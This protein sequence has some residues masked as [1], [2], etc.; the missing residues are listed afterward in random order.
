M[1]LIATPLGPGGGFNWIYLVE[2]LVCAVLSIFFLFYFNRLV[3]TIV[4]YAIRAWTWRK[5]NAYIDI[6]AL[7]ISLLGGRIFFKSIRYHAHNITVFVHDGHITWRYWLAQVQDA[8]IFQ[9]EEDRPKR[10]ERSSSEAEEKASQRSSSHTQNKRSRSRSIGKAETAGGKKKDLPCRLSIKVSGVEAFIYNR[11][12]LYD[13]V[14]EATTEKTKPTSRQSSSQADSVKGDAVP[15]SPSDEDGKK[16]RFAVPIQRATTNATGNAPQ[17]PAIPVWLGLLPVKVECRRAAAAVGNENTPSVVTAKVEKA[18]GTIDAGKAATPLDLFKLLFNFEIENA[19]ARM[20]PNRDFK[21]LQLDAAQRILR[22]K[23]GEQPKDV[24]FEE[25]VASKVDRRW[26][27]F[28][29]LF[30]RSRRRS[31]AGSVRTASMDSFDGDVANVTEPLTGAPQWHGLARYLDDSQGPEHDEWKGI[32]YAKATT[33]VD[34]PKVGFRFYWDIPGKIPDIATD[35]ETLLNAGFADDINGSKP[36]DYGLDFFVHGGSVTYGPWAD[37]QRIHLQQVFFPAQYVDHDP[38]P[39]L[40]PGDTRINT[41]FKIYVSVEEA[42]TLRVPTREPSKDDQWRGHAD[43]GQAAPESTGQDDRDGKHGKHKKHHRRRKTKSNNPGVDARP[44]GWLDITVKADSTVNYSQDMFSR[45]DGFKNYLDLDVKATEMTSS[46]NHGL[47]WRSGPITLGADLS[48]PLTWN[49]LRRWPF[50][51]TIN[52]ME[53]FI[54]RDHMFLIIDI[55]NDWSS[56]AAPAFFTFVPYHYDINMTFKNWCMFLNVND[57]NIIDDPDN[58][59]RNDFVT[60]EGRHMDGAIH[61]PL[62]HYR[63]KRN[64]IVFEVLSLDMGMRMLSP[65]RNTMHQFLENRQVANLPKLTLKG[66]FDQNGEERPGLV[67]ILRFDIN[68]W[69]LDLKAYGQLIR[70]FINLKENYFGDYVHFKTLEEFQNASSDLEQA[71]LITAS[72]PNPSPINEMDVLLNIVVRDTTVMLPTNLYNGKEFVRIECPAADLNLR[73]VSYYLDMALNLSPLS[74]LNASTPSADESSEDTA[75]STQIYVSHVDLYGHRCFGLPPNEPAYVDQWDIDVGALTG[76]CSS[77][78]IRDLAFA[79]KAL[80]YGFADSENALPVFSPISF[81][82]VTFVQVKTDILR[83]W[84]HVGNDAILLAAQPITVSTNDWAGDRFS[85]RVSVMAPEVTLACIDARSV[86]RRLVQERRGQPVKTLALLQTGAT[87]DVLIRSRHFEEE[88]HKQ[89]VHLRQCDLRTHRVPFLIHR[90][91]DLPVGPPPD[92]KFEPPAM[93]YPVLPPPI[94]QAGQP[95]RRPSSIKSVRSVQETHL[96]RPKSSTSSIATSIRSSTAPGGIPTSKPARRPAASRSTSREDSVESSTSTVSNDERRVRLDLPP[97]TIAFSSSYAKPHFPLDL[98]EPDE[99][100]VP[101]Y[102]IYQLRDDKSETSSVSIDLAEPDIDQETSHTSVIIK[103]QPGIRAYVEPGMAFTVARLLG[104][105]A[106]RTPEDIMDS[107]TMDIMGT[108]DN[109]YK[110]K[111]GHPSVLEIAASLPGA[112]LRVVDQE[113]QES[114]QMD[115]KLTRLEQLVR[116][117]A[118]PAVDRFVQT[119]TLHTSSDGVEMTMFRK[120][121]RQDKPVLSLRVDDIL[122]WLSLG[123]SRCIHVTVRDT[124]LDIDG[125]KSVYLSRVA[126]RILNLVHAILP[127]FNAVQERQ[128]GMLHSLIYTLAQ[129]SDDIGNPPALSRMT[130][131]LRAFPEHYRNQDSWKILSRFRWI[132]QALPPKARDELLQRF[133]DN[134]L[135]CPSDSPAQVLQSWAGR[136]N[137]D[138]PNADQALVFKQLFDEMDSRAMDYVHSPPLSMTAQSE[139]ITL[140]INT[141]SRTSKLVLDETSVGLDIQPPTVPTGLMLVDENKR[142]KSTFQLHNDSIALALDWELYEIAEQLLPVMDEFQKLSNNAERNVRRRSATGK[143]EDE[144]DRHDFHIVVSTD[145]GSITLQTIN[146]RLLTRAEGLKMSLIGTTQAGGNYGPCATA[147]LNVDRAMMQLHGPERRIWQSLLTGPSLYVDH[148]QPVEGA[149][150]APSVVIAGAYN[151]LEIAIEEQVP[152]IVHVA[153]RIVLDEVAQVLRLVNYINDTR[154]IGAGTA[155]GG[156]DREATSSQIPP[157]LSIALLAGN[158]QLE[159]SLLQ[160]LSYRLDGTAAS[161]KLTPDLRGR[162]AFGLDFDIGRQNHAFINLSHNERYH[163]QLLELPPINGRVGYNTIDDGPYVNVATTVETVEIDAAAIQAVTGVVNKPEVQGIFR[164]VKGSIRDMTDHVNSLDFGVS[165]VERTSEKEQSKALYE[166]RFALL[167]IRVSGSTPRVRGRSTAEIEFGIGPLHMKASNRANFATAN[168]MIPEVKASVQDIGARLWIDDHGNHVPCGK[169]VMDVNVNFSIPVDDQGHATRELQLRSKSLEVNAYPETA[170]TM[171]DVIN[172]LQDRLRDLDVSKEVEYMRRLRDSRRQTLVQGLAGKKAVAG[173]EE[174]NFSLEDLLAIRTTISLQDIQISWL[175]NQQYAVLPKTRP[176]DTVLTLTSIEFTTR[177][178]NEA[179]LTITDVLLQLSRKAL[180]K[181]RRAA[182]SALLPQ[183]VFSV[184]YWKDGKD[185][186]V[187]LRA[188]GKPLDFKLESSFIIPIAAV[189]HSVE[190]CLDNFKAGTAAWQ[191]TPTATGAPRSKAIDMQRLASVIIEVDF[192]GAQVYM[193]GAGPENSSSSNQQGSHHGRYGQFAADGEL[194]ST[195]LTTPGI[196]LKAEYNSKG[197]QPRMNGELRI[198]ASSNKLLP[199]FVPLMVEVSKSV[200]QVVQHQPKKAPS[201]AS[202]RLS[203]ATAAPQRLLED[204]SLVS[205]TPAAIFGK[206]KVDLGLRVCKQEFAL[207]CQPIAKVD[208]KAALEDFY[209]TMNTVESEDAGHFFAMSASITGLAAQVKHVYSREPTFSFDMQSIVMSAMNS[210]HLSGDN[211][212]SAIIKFNPTKLSINAKQFQDLLIFR[213]I[214]LPPEIRMAQAA[215][216]VDDEHKPDDYFA[217]RYRN[218]AGS[219]AFP[220]NAT[221][222]FTELAVNMDLGQSIGKTAFTITDLWASQQKT[223]DSEEN[224][225]VGLSELALTSTGRMSG[226]VRLAGLGVRTSIRWP[227]ED[228]GKHRTPIIQASIGFDKLRAKAAFEYQAFAFGDIE[229]FDFLMYNVRESADSSD[230]LVAV[231]DCGI[232]YVFCHATSPAQAFGLYQA[233]DRLIQEKQTTYIA[234]LRDIEKHLRRESLILPGRTSLAPVPPDAVKKKTEKK[235][236]VIS[237]H[238]DVVLTLGEISFGVYPNTFFDSQILKLEANNIQAR[239]AVGLEN[240]RIHSGLGMT[241]GQLQVAL[242]SVRRVTAVPKAL[243]VSVDDV[244]H[245]AMNAKGGIILRVPKVVA[246]MQTWQAPDSYNVDFIF[247]SL[248]AGK[249]D[250]G[251]NLSRINF[252]QGMW[253]AHSRSL[254][255]RMGKPLPVS[256]V[257]ISASAEEE[258]AGGGK[259]TEPQEKITAEVGLPQSRYE[260]RALEP[261]VIETPQLRDMG[262]ATPPLEWI[263]LQRDRLPNVTHQIIIVSLLEVAKEV[264]DAYTRILGSA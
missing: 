240:G 49:T 172:H 74:L 224:L 186:S 222:L 45:R 259:H 93:T 116:V 168:H 253:A 148:L 35:S 105:L 72:V 97:T 13:I 261:P 183:V 56:G 226:F 201:I 53:L 157:D 76:E 52:D 21:Q 112:A 171:V 213:E 176:E 75:S 5:Y 200:K 190:T 122:V 59:E 23:E 82:N 38:T 123:T 199:N 174:V 12:P 146:L 232:A 150:V 95:Q 147:L 111:N 141:K 235:A 69:G 203:E 207:T 130:Y 7:Q 229:D 6:T 3:G 257:K 4:S 248:F 218:V 113:D 223:S 58:F 256:A 28:G 210:K 204:D 128:H 66:T 26:A 206:T 250:V 42:V 115:F 185:R 127:G 100:N 73:V 46:V 228:A 133:R 245:S 119:M 193:C 264:E 2:I 188:T 67:D 209:F 17:R 153:D 165:A 32:E 109:K 202:Q 134:H 121:A 217:Q 18:V 43:A 11:S 163:Q 233:F 135:K 101:P 104:K 195:T 54:L 192:A 138:V 177:G 50:N 246:S 98:V 234:S 178:G 84:T 107:F 16:S 211:G 214:W 262:E 55:V 156:L 64:E 169:V 25:R 102:P 34:C 197:E 63:P 247:K 220:W 22:D 252:I 68:A 145:D 9:V 184:G 230:R 124:A 162:R 33:L 236:T 24:S 158:T 258:N 96:L 166:L 30:R 14:V 1:A 219:A 51:I 180:S 47:L 39:T 227:P 155:K 251:W 164:S 212:I 62:E 263:G 29:H 182:N 65:P 238:T 144:L 255:S 81:N 110:A 103:V 90:R 20:I 114:N 125:T 181:Q 126:N 215:A 88:K 131:I 40:M 241:L 243:E 152:G 208:A 61:I 89:Q 140:A 86:S 191:S 161:V 260:Y 71:N 149:D 10:K 48:Q 154:Q 196:A 99:T 249:I 160:A 120:S 159:I 117:R 221:V 244:V 175:V 194:I 136:R 137:W 205:T 173:E 143:L 19:V 27:A 91:D 80:A 60:L 15:S 85:Q 225:C 242:A 108:I 254:A 57:A 139:T 189:K 179:R 8:E 77:A 94:N 79:M 187:A 170:P 142:T 132:L 151:E 237:L 41:V 70:Q 167:G 239:F 92:A 37:R 83:V 44:Y 129:H 36:P 198:D 118:Q 31:N 216:P 78:L 87:V 231:L 106:P